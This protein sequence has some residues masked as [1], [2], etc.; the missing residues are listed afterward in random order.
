[1]IILASTSARRR[2]MM[3]RF[4][5]KDEYKAIAPGVDEKIEKDVCAAEK[6]KILSLRK[7]KAI[8][9]RCPD[10]IVIGSDTVVA[11]GDEILEKPRDRDDAYRMLRALSGK[12]HSV[13]SGIAVVRGDKSVVDVVSTDVA[14]RCLTDDEIYKYI[15]TCSPYDK[16]GAYGIQ[17][18]AGLFVE[19]IDGDVN[20]VI[21]MPLTRLYLILRDDFGYDLLGGGKR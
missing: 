5:S 21:G 6:V 9:A 20:T 4:L 18:E 11:L 17:E 14:F 13:Y 7:A 1:M 3:E 16:A 12:V 19:K 15:D 8:A 10:D 2:E